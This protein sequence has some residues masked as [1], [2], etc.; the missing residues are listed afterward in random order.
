MEGN[1][2]FGVER[3]V[4][5]NSFLDKISEKSSV[6]I[7]D[8]SSSRQMTFGKEFYFFYLLINC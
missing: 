7:L 8:I 3:I 2:M 1:K 4:G 6:I 5:K